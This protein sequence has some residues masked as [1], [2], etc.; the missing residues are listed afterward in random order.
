MTTSLFSPL[1]ARQ[2]IHRTH[3]MLSTTSFLLAR[4]PCMLRATQ[5]GTDWLD[6]TSV[7]HGCL[8]SAGGGGSAAW[9]R[10]GAKKRRR[11]LLLLLAAANGAFGFDRWKKK[12]K[13]KLCLP[14]ARALTR[15]RRVGSWENPRESYKGCQLSTMFSFPF[16]MAYLFP[17]VLPNNF[18][19]K[20]RA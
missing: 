2:I 6:S 11:M 12:K 4:A 16:T 19:A 1:K 17:C 13:K 14:A 18:R 9:K 20:S 8:A 7:W 10:A 15:V 5:L 3:F